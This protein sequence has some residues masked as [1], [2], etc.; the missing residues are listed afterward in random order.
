MCGDQAAIG[1]QPRVPKR[2]KGD[3]SRRLPTSLIGAELV[4]ICSG[5]LC[6]VGNAA[7]PLVCPRA[8]GPEGLGPSLPSGL[9][10][11]R[12]QK[13]TLFERAL[14]LSLRRLRGILWRRGL[15]GFGDRSDL[16]S[17][18]QDGKF[19]TP[20][21]SKGLKLNLY[22]SDGPLQLSCSSSKRTQVC[23]QIE[24]EVA[25]R[26]LLHVGSL[27]GVLQNWRSTVSL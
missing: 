5:L 2:T 19:S 7:Q 17:T 25:V 24:K 3:A 12:P 8:S 20:C 11:A 13:Q 21:P 16:W 9:S 18:K 26:S 23:E 6:I 1:Q 22:L 15:G 4:H 14:G 27:T 10:H